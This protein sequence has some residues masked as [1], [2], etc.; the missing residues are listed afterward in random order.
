MHS[1]ISDLLSSYEPV[2]VLRSSGQTRLAVPL[3]Q[4]CS[5]GDFASEARRLCVNTL[6]TSGWLTQIKIR[7]DIC[8]TRLSLNI[9]A[10]SSAFSKVFLSE[11]IDTTLA[12]VP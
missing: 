12:S 5:G 9:F 2:S 8:I 10:V 1:Y 4:I 3:S 6:R 11:K 7:K